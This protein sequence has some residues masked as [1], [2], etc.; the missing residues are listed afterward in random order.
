MEIDEDTGNYAKGTDDPEEIEEI[1]HGEEMEVAERLADEFDKEQFMK[2]MDYE[3][4]QFFRNWGKRSTA[5]TADEANMPYAKNFMQALMAR[6]QSDGNVK[7]L[8]LS[9]QKLDKRLKSSKCSGFR[10]RFEAPPGGNGKASYSNGTLCI[11]LTC[12]LSP[13]RRA[14]GSK[15]L[16]KSTLHEIMH[17]MLDVNPRFRKTYFDNL[18]GTIMDEMKNGNKAVAALIVAKEPAEIKTLLKTIWKH[19]ADIAKANGNDYWEA[20][21][22]S[23]TDFTHSI[24][25][26]NLNAYQIGKLN[27]RERFKELDG[28]VVN[29]HKRIGFHP[30]Q[31]YIERK[32]QDKKYGNSGANEFMAHAGS[33]FFTDRNLFNAYAKELPETFKRIERAIEEGK[34]F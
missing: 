30:A 13:Q 10:F 4:A 19:Y 21:V 22:V 9:L 27:M 2:D 23:F 24:I 11:N 5:W 25:S 28:V 20:S 34:M 3:Q 17:A 7:N 33:L 18:H 31:Y 14:G 32:E 12:W 8:L 1:L 16:F 15:T 29:A 26:E 6:A